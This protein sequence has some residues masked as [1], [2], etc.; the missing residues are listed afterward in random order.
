M[1]K[2]ISLLLVCCVLM[3]GTLAG[4]GET[5]AT[6]DNA[7]LEIGDFRPVPGMKGVVYN[8]HTNVMFYMFNTSRVNGNQGYGY[9]Y[10]GEYLNENC[11]NCWYINGKIVE[12]V[13]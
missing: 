5:Q 10:F 6:E 13:D 4:C 7:A 9:G 8:L 3:C 2:R 12:K 1:K 11:N